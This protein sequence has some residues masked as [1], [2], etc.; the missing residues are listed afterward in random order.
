MRFEWRGRRYVDVSDDEVE[1]EE[2]ERRDA[3]A[4]LEGS[5]CRWCSNTFIATD[6]P[7]EPGRGRLH[8]C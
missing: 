3:L 7:R 5:G 4:C 1:R 2:S 6:A 8:R